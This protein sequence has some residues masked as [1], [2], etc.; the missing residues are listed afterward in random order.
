[1]FARGKI[2]GAQNRR[3]TLLSKYYNMRIG[4]IAPLLSC[5]FWPFSPWICC[6]ARAAYSSPE[7][8]GYIWHKRR[9]VNRTYIGAISKVVAA[10]PKHCT[11]RCW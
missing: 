1:M 6:P 10:C 2:I 9:K 4:C 5:H 11:Q 8:L 7:G 3:H